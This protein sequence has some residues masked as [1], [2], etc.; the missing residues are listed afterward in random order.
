MRIDEVVTP[1]RWESAQLIKR[2]CGPFL[3]QIKGRVDKLALFRGLGPRAG[4]ASFSKVA[5]PVNRYPMSTNPTVHE[6]SDAW[7][8]DHFGISFRRNAVFATGSEDE[9]GGYGLLY[10][11]FPIG[12]FKICYSPV[13]KDLFNE[14]ESFEESNGHC[15]HNMTSELISDEVDSILRRGRYVTGPLTTAIKSKHEIMI[16]CNEYYQLK[17]AGHAKGILAEL[18]NEIV[19]L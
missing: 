3:Q 16:H 4:N 18:Y 19:Q 9:A 2:D 7:F 11:I 17:V 5:C 1:A 8:V 10:A 14:W 13:I 15:L 12:D 6:I